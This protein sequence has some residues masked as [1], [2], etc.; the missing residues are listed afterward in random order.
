MA[1]KARKKKKKNATRRKKRVLRQHGRKRTV[2]AKKARRVKRA[3]KSKRASKKIAQKPFLPATGKELRAG[4][5]KGQKENAK[6]EA[7]IRLGKERG[8]ITYEIGRA[9]C[10]E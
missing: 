7:L 2:R 3:Q 1:K 4:S 8:Y 5:R 6:V 10:R 9:S